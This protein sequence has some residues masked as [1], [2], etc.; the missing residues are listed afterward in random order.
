MISENNLEYIKKAI[1]E[2]QNLEQADL[3]IIDE[4][5]DYDIFDEIKDFKF[6]KCIKHDD[7]S[8]YGACLVEAFIFARD[9]NYKY[10]ITFNPED[11]SFIK[12]IPNII[13]NLDYG[14][15]IITCSRILENTNYCK[16]N[17]NTLDLYEKLSINLRDATGIDIT[18]PL[19]P[20][21][22]YNLNNINTLELTED[23]HGALLQLFIQ[24]IYFGYNIIEI[25]AESGSSFGNEM[26]LY[27]DPLDIFFVIIETEKYLY[28]KGSIN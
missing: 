17:E 16:I 8:G 22:G 11:N 28:D 23:S 9:F 1:L 18:D 3:L 13:N 14:Y 19:S 26:Y 6:V 10:L 5:S 2:I 24:G 12:D 7:T 15:D 27:D 4:G 21:K 25:P 20:N